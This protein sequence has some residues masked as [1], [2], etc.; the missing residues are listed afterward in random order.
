MTKISLAPLQGLTDS[1]FRNTYFNYFEG[2]DKAYTPYFATSP[3]A[4]Y[5]KSLLLKKLDHQCPG[6][7]LIPQILSKDVEQTI[8]IC[9]SFEELGYEEVNLNIGCPYPR[10]HRKM[11]GSGLLP[12][13]EYLEEY[14]SKVIENIHLKF[15]VKIRLGLKNTN[16]ID[17][18][19]PIFN[20]LNLSEVIIHPRTASQLYEGS[21][22]YEKFQEAASK[23]KH[24]VVYNG[25][26]NTPEDF[27]RV[28]NQNPN[29][30]EYMLGRGILRDP[31]LPMKIKS[32]E[33]PDKE[34][35]KVILKTFIDELYR[36]FCKK[37]RNSD[38]FPSVMKEFWLYLSHSFEY[39]EEIFN[40]IKVVKDKVS[41]EKE[42]N[43]IFEDY[44][45]KS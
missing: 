34:K 43:T 35:Q 8:N 1:I 4:H 27:Y 20:K 30:T 18:L 24:K 28:K 39:S 41:Y 37:R 15:S 36:N 26:I 10:V 44:K 19:I 5:R 32:I 38:S 9:H 17:A 23:I 3:A 29:I 6:M 45:I 2:I 21:I 13:P 25:D 33:L 12:H 7:E 40:K 11:R 16:E 22:N 14:L 42:V 31:F